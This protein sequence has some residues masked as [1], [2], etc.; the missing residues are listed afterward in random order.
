MFAFPRFCYSQR[1]LFV[2]PSFSLHLWDGPDGVT[3][4]DL[5]S[6]AYSAFLDLG[7]ESD[8]NAMIGTEFG[9]R[10]GD[11]LLVIIRHPDSAH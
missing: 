10:V 5:P 9:V 4:A 1:P 2:I 7:W 11:L 8:P 3:G 6:K